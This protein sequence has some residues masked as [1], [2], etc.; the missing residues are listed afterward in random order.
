MTLEQAQ[1]L[2]ELVR[3]SRAAVVVRVRAEALPEPDR[4][5]AWAVDD[6]SFRSVVDFIYSMVS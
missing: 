1:E 3:A 5:A 6:A 2:T 4:Q